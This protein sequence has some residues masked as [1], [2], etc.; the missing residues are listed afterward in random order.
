MWD[1]KFFGIICSHIDTFDGVRKY[2]LVF[3]TLSLLLIS[4]CSCNFPVS[5]P[6]GTPNPGLVSNS[7]SPTRTP[8]FPSEPTAIT[9]SPAALT[10]TPPSPSLTPTFSFGTWPPPYFGNPGPAQV[11]AIPAAFPPLSGMETVNF[12]LLGSDRRALS[13]RTDTLVVVSFRPRDQSVS[14]ISIPRDLYVYIPGWKMQRINTAYQQGELSSY[15]GGGAQLLKDT[16]GYNL[17]I[18]IDH[19]AMVEFNGFRQIV[20]TLGGIDVPLVCAFTDWHIIDP[21]KS[22]QNEDNW[23]LFTIGPGVVHMDGELALWYARS[24]MRSSDFDRGRRQQEVLRAI[25]NQS[26]RLNVIPKLPELYDQL[27]HTVITDLSLNNLL[28]LAP[29]AY[30]LSLPH[31]RSYYINKSYVYGWRTPTGAAVLLPNQNAIL[32]LVAEAM[33]PP[34][35]NETTNWNTT[36]EIWNGTQTKNLDA[37]AAER[38]HYTGFETTLSPADHQENTQTFLYDFSPDQDP[39]RSAKLLY[40]IGIPPANLI[41]TPNPESPSAYRLILGT[42][43]NPCFDP[44][45]LIH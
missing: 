7:G 23:A 42:D 37:L 25:F 16:V 44:A 20:E 8:F 36:V 2:W 14:L 26:I 38:L 45:H 28:E 41:S 1:Y 34:D 35:E 3:S 22:D 5:T 39:H 17:G 13:F 32:Q 33:A 27:S 18:H 40:S 11:T 30:N 9:P 10:S 43:F 12:L 6:T 4:V 31:I 15:P 21:T 24:R 29:L 19:I